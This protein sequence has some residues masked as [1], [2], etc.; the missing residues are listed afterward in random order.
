[1]PIR[2]W[3]AGGIVRRRKR[4]AMA[5]VV[6]STRLAKPYQLALTACTFVYVSANKIIRIKRTY[7]IDHIIFRP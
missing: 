1:M 4:A 2:R 3:R 7:L 6:D 5:Q